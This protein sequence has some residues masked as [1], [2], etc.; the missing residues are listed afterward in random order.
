[1]FGDPGPGIGDED[2]LAR[3]FTL[4]DLTRLVPPGTSLFSSPH[5]TLFSADGAVARR[6]MGELTGGMCP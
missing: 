4:D 1:M 2:R 6:P 3:A 5:L